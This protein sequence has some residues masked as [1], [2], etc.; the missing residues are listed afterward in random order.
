MTC[1]HCACNFCVGNDVREFSINYA[2]LRHLGTNEFRRRE[3][4]LSET[5]CVRAMTPVAAG[6][7]RA[8]QK[9]PSSDAITAAVGREEPISSCDMTHESKTFQLRVLEVFLQSNGPKKTSPSETSLLRHW[10]S[11]SILHVKYW[12]TTV[13]RFHTLLHLTVMFISKNKIS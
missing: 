6:L 8:V 10:Y 13:W 5:G 3:Q 12:L 1:T 11:T 4:P 7:P 9:L 2:V